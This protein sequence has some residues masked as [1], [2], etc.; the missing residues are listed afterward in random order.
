ML[1]IAR[2]PVVAQPPWRAFGL[3]LLLVGLLA[4]GLLLAATRPKPPPLFGP[5]GNGL[6]VISRDGDIF[7]VDTADGRCDRD[8]DR[9]RDR[10]RPALVAGRD[11]RALPSRVGRSAGRRLPDDRPGERIGPQTAHAGADDRPDSHEGVID[12]GA[13]AP[14]RAVA[15]RTQRRHHLDG[16]GLPDTLRRRHGWTCDHEARHRRHADELRLRSEWVRTSCSSAPRGSMGP[17]RACTSSVSTGRTS[18][19]SSNRRWMP[20]STA[21]SPG[22]PTGAGSP[23]PGSNPASSMATGAAR[24][25]GRTSASTS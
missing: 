18:A 17:T 20:R 22:R 14:L 24:P 10:Q 1:E 13:E 4:A 15:R 25:L 16:R 12:L 5:A 23:T 19:P 7:T 9:P 21:G 6:V 3:L 11:D 2:Q 8:R